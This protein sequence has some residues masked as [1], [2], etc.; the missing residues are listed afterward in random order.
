[1][2]YDIASPQA[3]L[4]TAIILLIVTVLSYG[5]NQLYKA[6]MAVRRYRH[7][8]FPVAPDHNFFFG[9]LLYLKSYLDKLPS[10]AHYQYA[11]GD[12]GLDHF[13]KEGCFYLDTWPVTG[14]ILLNFSPQVAAQSLNSGAIALNRP[15]ILP[16]FFKPI[17]GGPNLFD[18]GE[19]EW[20][21]WR[22]IFARGFGAE[23]VSSLVPGMVKETLVY[24]K[25]LE[26]KARKGEIF[27]LD[28]TTL[29]FTI[30]LIGK[31]ILCVE[32]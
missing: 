21:P 27:S 4:S 16:R 31:T 26:E 11:M 29:R 25:I 23:Q 6:R 28:A 18:L 14:L 30:D 22:T 10:N 12:I 13:S 24:C 32:S 9:H 5:F 1:M 8:G 15:S 19:K 2:A 17:A 3:I 20:R 7:L